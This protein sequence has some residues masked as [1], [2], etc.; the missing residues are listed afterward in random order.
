METVPNTG[1]ERWFYHMS[2]AMPTINMAATGANIKVLLKARGLKVADVQAICG[3]AAVLF[4]SCLIRISDYT[5][6]L[7]VNTVTIDA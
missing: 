7:D 5:T 2:S 3:L 6:F 4:L 1:S